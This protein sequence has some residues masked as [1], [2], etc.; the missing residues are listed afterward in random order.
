MSTHVLAGSRHRKGND[1]GPFTCLVVPVR[2][3]DVR[4]QSPC[5]MK[6]RCQVA[7]IGYWFS[8]LLVAIVNCRLVHTHTQ[9]LSSLMP[10]HSNPPASCPCTATLQPHAHAQQPSSL[11]HRASPML[12]Y[13]ITQ[14]ESM[15]TPFY[16]V[17]ESCVHKLYL[18]T[19]MI[20]AD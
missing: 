2:C 19:Y 4:Q 5:K 9:Q 15:Q 3:Q 7:T 17:S 20:F 1:F 10:M 16:T 14:L 18:Y 12:I 8:L 6:A 11:M 13:S